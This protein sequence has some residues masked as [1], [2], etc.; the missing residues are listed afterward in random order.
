VSELF[1]LVF[2]TGGD[3]TVFI[4]PAGDLGVARLRAALAGMEGE[5]QEGHALDAKMTK[6]V[7]KKMI[8]RALS[9]KEATALLKKLG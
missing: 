9:R 7:P 2:K 8:G 4:Q 3:I 1:W 6:K 5:F